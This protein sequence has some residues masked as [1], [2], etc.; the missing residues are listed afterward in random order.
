MNVVNKNRLLT[1]LGIE[2]PIVQG[3]LGGGPSTPELVAAVSNAGGLGSLGA[4]YLTPDQISDAIR[5]IRELTSRPFNVN[6]FAGGWNTNQDFDAAPMLELLAEVHGRLGLPPPAVPKPSP[7]PFPGQ[8]EVVLDARPPIFSFT[9]GIPDRDA[10]SRLK[11][12]GILIVGT[13]TTVEEAR[14]LEQAGVD[15]IAAQ[16]AEAG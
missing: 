9:F 6:L 13:A 12:R 10:I 1:L 3:P 14:A 16:G 11:S 4:A 8:L 2:H 15:A 5:K 7:D